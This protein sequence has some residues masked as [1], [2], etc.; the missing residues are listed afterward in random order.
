MTY[1]IYLA[2]IG[3][4]IYSC[5]FAL[6]LWKQKNKPGAFVIVVLSVIA[7]VLPYFTYIK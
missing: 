2:V 7:L 4:V 3:V 5:G 6:S 1:T